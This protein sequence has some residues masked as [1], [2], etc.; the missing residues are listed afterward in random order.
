MI[1]GRLS[2][3][4][5]ILLLL[6]MV[7]ATLVLLLTFHQKTRVEIDAEARQRVNL[8]VTRLQNILY[9]TLTGQDY[10]LEMARLNLSVTAMD[11]NIRSIFLADESGRIILAN[12]YSMEDTL[13][14]AYPYFDVN[15]A[16]TVVTKNRPELVPA[17]NQ[18]SILYG[19]YPVLL[20][21]GGYSDR[22]PNNFGVLYVEYDYSNQVVNR[23][24]QELEHKMV[25]VL[26][27]L[28][29]SIVIALILHFKVSRRLVNLNSAATAI[30]QGDYEKR[31]RIEGKDEIFELGQAFDAMADNLQHD[32]RRREDVEYELKLLN[33][34][35]EETVASR[36]QELQEAQAIAHIGNWHWNESDGSLLWSD[37]IYRIFAMDTSETID[38]DRFVSMIHPEDIAKLNTAIERAF[39][40]GER[41]SVDHR[42]ITS[43]GEVK[44]VHEEGI[45]NIDNKTGQKKHDRSDSGY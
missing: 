39:G 20:K 16:Q 38:F 41:Y 9:N 13:A 35:L 1:K 27:T 25:Y 7:L 11:E 30:A 23:L 18:E 14:S 19:Y 22:N 2:I 3:L 36:T 43:A 15:M 32:M 37:E 44:W 21:L 31:S 12:R 40:T 17:S 28:V 4:I 33:E 6:S 29:M 8:D 5:P 10:D 34:N 42:I 45:P 26:V 24:G